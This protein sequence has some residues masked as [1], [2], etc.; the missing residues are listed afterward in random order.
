MQHVCYHCF[1][2]ESMLTFEPR[3]KKKSSNFLHYITFSMH[4]C[5]YK[6]VRGIAKSKGHTVAR[7]WEL[8]YQIANSRWP[9][10]CA[11][12]QKYAL[13]QE[14]MCLES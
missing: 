9:E 7:Y 13:V 10:F 12:Q 1:Q 6:H 2:R 11:I 8:V 14:H 3:M 4:A 5:A